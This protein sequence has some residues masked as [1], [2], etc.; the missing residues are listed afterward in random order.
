M[1]SS[2][3]EE[4]KGGYCLEVG[5]VILKV[6]LVISAVFILGSFELPH[7][8]AQTVTSIGNLVRGGI[9]VQTSFPSLTT[10]GPA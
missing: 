3:S 6:C 9:F 2:S 7:C 4:S 10:A 8:H 5:E 1:N